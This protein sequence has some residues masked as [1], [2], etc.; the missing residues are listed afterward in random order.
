ML[1]KKKTDCTGFGGFVSLICLVTV[2]SQL[3]VFVEAGITSTIAVCAWAL[4]FFVSLIRCRGILTLTESAGLLSMVLIW[5]AY[6]GI[7]TV[8]NEAFLR[9]ALPYVIALS[10]FV[11]ITGTM[12]GRLITRADLVRISK[13]FILG[14]TVLAAVVY[15]QYFWGEEVSS[16][17][18]LYTEKNST[19]QILMTAIILILTVHLN[20][21]SSK[22]KLL[23]TGVLVLLTAVLLLMRSRATII[24]FPVLVWLVLISKGISKKLKWVTVLVIVALA[25]V[26]IT[27]D[28]Y[29]NDLLEDILYAGRDSADLNDVTS[30]RLD[31]WKS[32]LTDLGDNWLFGH[33]RMKRESLILVSILEYGVIFGS[34]ILVVAVYPLY[35]GLCKLPKDNPYRVPLISVA[36]CY[37]ING[38]FEQLAPFGPGV[39]CFF[40]WFLL[41]ILFC[42]NWK[43]P[44][45][46][47]P[48]KQKSCL[49]GDLYGKR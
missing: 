47:S 35:Y 15:L 2:L 44:S 7:S 16:R 25:G 24:F 27:N 39:K 23:Y 13:A 14:C 45:P 3:P 26:L 32:F 46:N 48:A 5:A 36:S 1:A 4:L 8:I 10:M 12:V 42:P 22:G 34:L 37:A 20:E 29:R 18:Y 19:A 21:A 28:G 40:L 33:G 43:T 38:V 31:E 41:G 49:R 11:M 17:I 6:Y 9:S 30:G